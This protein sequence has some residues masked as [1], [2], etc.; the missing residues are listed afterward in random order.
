MEKLCIY[1]EIYYNFKGS[2]DVHQREIENGTRS[3]EQEGTQRTKYNTRAHP[4][5]LHMKMTAT[6]NSSSFLIKY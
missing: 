2:R 6:T 1:F 5:D 4:R 3:E